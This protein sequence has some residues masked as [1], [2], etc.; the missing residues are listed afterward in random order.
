MQIFELK[1]RFSEIES[2]AMKGTESFEETKNNYRKL[3]DFKS[4]V[5]NVSLIGL[6]EMELEELDIIRFKVLEGLLLMEM[7]L[8]DMK[9]LSIQETYAKLKNLYEING[10]NI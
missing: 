1:E 10:G 6:D 4:C 3:V 7:D 8:R 9:G 5:L 2:M